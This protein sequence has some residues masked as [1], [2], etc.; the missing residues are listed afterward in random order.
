MNCIATE[1]G[2]E[3]ITRGGL[4]FTSSV[5]GEFIARPNA[6]PFLTSQPDILFVAVKAPMLADAVMRVPPE[7][8]HKSI[9]IPFLNGFEHIDILR[10]HYGN[11]VAPGSISIEV[12]RLLSGVIHHMS[13]HAA[14]RIAS[15]DVDQK[16]LEKIKQTFLHAGISCNIYKKEAD[17]IWEKLVRLNAITCAIAASNK[18]LGFVRS[19]PK[20]R[21]ILEA[22]VK[23]AVRVARKEDVDSNSKTVMAQINV[24]PAS[25]RTS[26]ARDI[27]AGNMGELDAIAGAIVRKA[28]YYGIATPA[29]KSM[30]KKIS[31][32]CVKHQAKKNRS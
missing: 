8:V 28:A 13:P 22:C 6:E 31:S 26:L 5:F 12:A 21:I 10:N 7:R 25:L 11:R 30:I 3:D 15:D 27:E 4:H 2:A 18:S 9:I 17:V 14:V 32:Q 16:K 1:K 20:W 24:L 29:I 23:E 19:D